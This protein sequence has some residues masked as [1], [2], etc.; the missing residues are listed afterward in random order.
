M[1]ATDTNAKLAAQ[2]F[3]VM[4]AIKIAQIVMLLSCELI[5]VCNTSLFR[6]AR[7]GQVRDVNIVKMMP[8]R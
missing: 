4:M 5:A 7:G 6:L 2:F 1:I 8:R 3:T